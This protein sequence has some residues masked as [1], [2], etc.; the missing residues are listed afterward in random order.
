[1]TIPFFK[2]WA[3]EDLVARLDMAAEHGCIACGMDVDAAGFPAFRALSPT[4]GVR[5]GR[6]IAKLVEMAHARGMKCIIKGIM[7]VA[8]ARIAADNGADAL[9]VSNHG[10]RAIDCTPGVAEVLPGIAEDVGD[11]TLIMA[12]GGVRYGID[13]LR[14]LALG[15]RLVLICRPV[16]I[17]VHGDEEN[18]LK[19]YFDSLREQLV[20]AMRLTGCANLA[21]IT[22]NV[23]C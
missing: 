22:R 20:A 10:G 9:I 14:M 8:D 3:P 12:D 1:M 21:S 19:L 23:L 11:R 15:A 6:D 17:A 2:P 7:S 16:A 18:G 13:V 4:Y 5:S